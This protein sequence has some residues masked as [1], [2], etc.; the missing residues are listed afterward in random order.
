VLKERVSVLNPLSIQ[1]TL[2]YLLT[3]FRFHDGS[4]EDFEKIFEKLIADDTNDPYSDAWASTFMPTAEALVKK[5]EETEASDKSTAVALYKRACVV[6]RISRFPYIDGSSLKRKCYEAQKKAYIAGAQ[7]WDV[8]MI[9][10]SIPFEDGIDGDGKEIPLYIRNPP[11][12]SKNAPCPVM[13]LIT[14]L[15]G[16]RPDNSEVSESLSRFFPK[17]KRVTTLH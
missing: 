17:S 5:A 16:H 1:G 2:T 4:I 13:L 12:A 3:W 9:D 6:Y 15:D 14:G 7:L 11:T 10:L 8:P